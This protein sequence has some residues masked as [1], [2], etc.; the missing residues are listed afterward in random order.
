MLNEKTCRNGGD[1]A[2]F[3]EPEVA[4]SELGRTAASRVAKA[5]SPWLLG[6]FAL[7]TLI[8]MAASVEL[9]RIHV[10]VHTDPDYHSVCAMSEGVNCETVALSPYSVFAG[11]PVSVWGIAGYVVMALLALWGGFE[12]RPHSAWPLGLLMLLACFSVVTSGI[13]AF[14]SVTSIDSVC[15]F[16]TVTYAVNAALLALTML[17]WR[18][19]RLPLSKLLGADARALRARPRMLAALVLAAGAVVLCLHGLIP[20]YW[21]VPGW[22]DLPRLP[23]GLDAD[24]HHWIGA[25]DPRLTI[26]EFS[27]YQCPHCRAAHRE[28][29]ALA[30]KHP[31]Q[32]RLIHRHLPLDMACHPVLR[33]PFHTHACLFAEAAEC[34]GRQDRFWEMNDALF[35]IQD[36]VK[37]AEVDPVELAVRLGLNRVEFKRCLQSHAT[38]ERIEAD[39]KAAMDRQLRGTPTFLVGD[40]VHLGKLREV[41]LERLIEEAPR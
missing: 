15:L 37:A 2:R 25:R 30:A 21:Q 40:E 6:A 12:R 28:I 19:A 10:F 1:T 22:A 38:A 26:V 5:P 11:I 27:D 8:G 14:I 39:L 31:D 20:K 18:Q 34:A 9:T 23:S 7:F 24:G 41:E 17:A 35:S 3:I 29:R 33:R 13:L 16:C 36:S 32:V 4:Q